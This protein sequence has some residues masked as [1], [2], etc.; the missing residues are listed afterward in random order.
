MALLINSPGGSPVQSDLIARRIRDWAR[1]KEIPVLV[2]CEDVAASGGYWLA[3]AGDEVFVN[4]ASIVGSIGVISSGF[5]LAD[6]IARYGIERRVYT[7]GDKKSTL[8]P[9]RPENA[10]DVERLKSIQGEIHQRFKDMVEERRG[11]LLK[12]DQEVLFSGEFW[13]GAKAVELGLADGLG[14]ARQVLRERFGDKVVLVPVRR[15]RS[16]LRRRLGMAAKG[17]GPEM[18]GL[19]APQDWAA[20]LLSAVEER[21]LWSRFGL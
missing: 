15:P 10:Q 4:E 3:C 21:S 8:D 2:F 7:A 12:A 17:Y 13:T 20:G 19:P 11:T 18:P 1:E 6:F 5:G 9:F 16:W 14:E